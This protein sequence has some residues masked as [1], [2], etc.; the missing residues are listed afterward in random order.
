MFG[1][2]DESM[3]VSIKTI[4]NMVSE[5]ILGRMDAATKDTGSR[6]SSMGLA[7]TLSQKSKR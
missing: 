6:A 4:R 1:T 5:F 2:T 3:K 7:P